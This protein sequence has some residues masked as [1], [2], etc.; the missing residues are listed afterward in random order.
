[1]SEAEV[2]FRVENG[3]GI[4]TLNRPKALN[5]LT[6][7]MIREMERVIPEWEKD[8]AVKAAIVRGAGDRAFCAGGDVTGLYREMRDDP[9]GTL[10]RDFFREEYVINRRIYR[11]AKPWVSLIDGINMGAASGFRCTARTRW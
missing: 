6:M 3:L 5:S 1:M 2:L 7:G 10:R 9:Q 4:M 11:F 8:P